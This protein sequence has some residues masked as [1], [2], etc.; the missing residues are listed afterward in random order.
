MQLRTFP[1]LRIEGCKMRKLTQAVESA[2]SLSC[3][4]P[5]RGTPGGG[6]ASLGPSS[7]RHE[8]LVSGKNS[9]KIRPHG[10]AF[11]GWFRGKPYPDQIPGNSVTRALSPEQGINREWVSEA[12]RQCGTKMGE[13]TALCLIHTS[14]GTTTRARSSPDARFTLTHP[15]PADVEQYRS[16]PPNVFPRA[17]CANTSY[18]LL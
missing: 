9:G 12:L 10:P 6:G 3:G 7:L 8:F 13:P 11:T 18:L 14:T 17:S 4:M 5:D 15:F 16:L 2:A 1:R